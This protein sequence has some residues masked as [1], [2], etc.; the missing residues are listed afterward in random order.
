VSS[1]NLLYFRICVALLLVLFVGAC[2]LVLSSL[3]KP[4]HIAAIFGAT[5]VSFMGSLPNV[6]LWKD[7]VNSDLLLVLACTMKAEDL[8]RLRSYCLEGTSRSSYTILFTIY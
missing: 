4:D 6:R 8:R 1:S 2:L 7:K 3:D 5:G